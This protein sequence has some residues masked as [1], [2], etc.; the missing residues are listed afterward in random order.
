MCFAVNLSEEIQE[1]KERRSHGYP[2]PPSAMARV[3]SESISSAPIRLSY[4]G[5]ALR[6]SDILICL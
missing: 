3:G 1:R 4:M 6:A 5:T 2:P